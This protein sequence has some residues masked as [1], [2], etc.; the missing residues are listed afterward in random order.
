MEGELSV[1]E[2]VRLAD[3]MVH[4][5]AAKAD[6]QA[7][8]NAAVRKGLLQAP[9]GDQYAVLGLPE[10]Q[11]KSVFQHAEQSGYKPTSIVRSLTLEE[12]NPAALDKLSLPTGS[13]VWHQVRTRLVNEQPI[14][15][16]H[17]FIPRDICPDLA[18]VD[19]SRASFQTTLETRFNTVIASI[20]ETF[21]L[22][23][24]TA[25]DAEVLMVEEEVTLLLVERMSFSVTNM[26]LVW[27]NIRVNPAQY[28]VVSGL[29][30]AAQTT[31]DQLKDQ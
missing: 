1:A 12:A 26:P 20:E 28:S 24:A 5:G 25:E 27:A 4:Y 17:N 10:P 7:V 21:A 2:S 3:M 18:S 30:P 23:A 31:L 15:N 19:L 22:G 29:W 8:L 6:M 16:Q 13:M 14:A 11:V 9:E